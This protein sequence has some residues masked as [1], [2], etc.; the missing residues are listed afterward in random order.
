MIDRD[1]IYFYLMIRRPPISTRTDT[2]FPYTTLFRSDGQD[3]RGVPLR[4]RKQALERLLDEAQGILR[5][6]GH[7]AHD[8]D[9]VLR[10]AC[11]LSLEGVVSKVASAPYRSGRSKDWLK[12]KCAERQEFVVAG[13]VPSTVSRKAVGS[14]VMGYYEEDR[15]S[16]RLNSSH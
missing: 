3:L 15:K 5:Y 1:T 14:L 13:Y 6:S 2:L 12:S 7:F 11:R 16:T 10:H 8:G 9:M 4:D